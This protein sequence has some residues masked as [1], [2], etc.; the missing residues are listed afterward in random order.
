[1]ACVLTGMSSGI[2]EEQGN[3]DR[4][5]A[6]EIPSPA[7]LFRSMPQSTASGQQ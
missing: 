2:N 1:M 4:S 3:D 5:P 6:G 7:L